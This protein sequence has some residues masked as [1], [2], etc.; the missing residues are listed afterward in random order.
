MRDWFTPVEQDLVRCA[1]SG[2]ERQ[3]VANLVWSA[4]ESALKVLETGLRRATR[5]VE[6]DVVESVGDKRW[7]RL[8][9]RAEDGAVFTGW[10]R[11]YG[12]FVLTFA[13]DADCDPPRSL[14]APP[15][16]AGAIPS[17]TWLGQLGRE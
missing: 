4:K 12:A 8:V 17:H 10:W 6:V 9:V 11:R 16:L 15:G 7:A 2:D 14:E 1:A 5:S 3:L 13:A